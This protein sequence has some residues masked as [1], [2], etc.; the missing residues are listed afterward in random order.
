[1]ELVCN[2]R[3][4][5]CLEYELSVSACSPLLTL[6]QIA[7]CL[8][9]EDS[10]QNFKNRAFAPRAPSIIWHP[11]RSWW[12][13]VYHVRQNF[14]AAHA[15]L[16]LS[17]MKYLFKNDGRYKEHYSPKSRNQSFPLPG[18]AA[19][20]LPLLVLMAKKQMGCVMC[21]KCQVLAGLGFVDL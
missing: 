18:A 2:I 9:L 5:E 11:E 20:C 16:L 17:V 7:R 6:T 21:S 1:M 14:L 15:V 4:S 13:N 3:K 19:A 12:A 10:W 8:T